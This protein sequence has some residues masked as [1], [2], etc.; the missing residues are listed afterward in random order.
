MFPKLTTIDVML[1]EFH[2]FIL[3]SLDSFS[4]SQMSPQG[5]CQPKTPTFGGSFRTPL[6]DA[7]FRGS[8]TPGKTPSKTPGKTPGKKRVKSPSKASGT[9]SV[10]T[11]PP[12]NQGDR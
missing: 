1:L 8:K 5:L 2:I 7:S 11:Q 3:D 10:P 9:S 4:K 6:G 12:A